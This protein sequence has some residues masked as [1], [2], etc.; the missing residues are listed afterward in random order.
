MTGR[1]HLH[2]CRNVG[3]HG[4]QHSQFVVEAGLDGILEHRQTVPLREQTG[5]ECRQGTMWRFNCL[6]RERQGKRHGRR[7]VGEALGKI[8]ETDAPGIQP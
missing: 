5:E 1:H 7:L 2:V 4:Q 6:G 3:P 8:V